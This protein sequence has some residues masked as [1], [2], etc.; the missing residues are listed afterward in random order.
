VPYVAG[1]TIGFWIR[2]SRSQALGQSLTP[3]L[4]GTLLALASWTSARDSGT[5]HFNA[6]YAA[7]GFFGVA[8]AHSGLNLLDDYFDYTNGSVQA[9]QE[10]A[11]GGVRA[12]M[13]KCSYLD[14]SVGQ[15]DI[16]KAAAGFIAIAAVLGTAILIGRGPVVLAFAGATLLLGV[17]YS[18]P[19][20]RLSYHGLGELITGF[21]FGPL[22]VVASYFVALGRID[23][24]AIWASVPAGLLTVNILNAHAIMDF[25]PDKAA[26]RT[27]LVVA[28]GSRWA[29][30]W[31]GEVL[32][33][34]SYASVV[35][36][37]VLGVFPLAALAVFATVPL[38]VEFSRL[39]VQY[40]NHPE[41]DAEPK[42]WYGPMGAWERI[43]K[44]GIGWFMVRWYLARNLLAAFVLTL[45]V[46]NFV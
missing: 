28:L 10:L 11:D 40:L 31:I 7:L 12:R 9:R 36:A 14:E 22:V 23:S 39:M 37:V 8:F 46:A 30:L 38:A 21:I 3:Y 15:K 41:V 19:P 2:A 20:L 1:K 24:Q 35:A 17:A 26:N 5:L 4:L 29:G 16:A 27:T 42:R 25:G 44:S 34:A 33:V 6:L 18:G 45:A 43:T 32:I 13:G